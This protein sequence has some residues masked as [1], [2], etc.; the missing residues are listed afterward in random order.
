MCAGH[1]GVFGV[2]IR[3]PHRRAVGRPAEDLSGR[4]ARWNVLAAGARGM[5]I[6]VRARSDPVEL[7]QVGL[8]D[9]VQYGFVRV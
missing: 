4:A 2:V 5:Y 9:L 8:L 6:F 1:I 3:A 7:I